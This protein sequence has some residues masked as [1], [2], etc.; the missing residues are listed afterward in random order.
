MVEEKGDDID[1]AVKQHRHAEDHVDDLREGFR[2]DYHENAQ[3]DVGDGSDDKGSQQV[4]F[5]WFFVRHSSMTSSVDSFVAELAHLHAQ[6]AVA[7][8]RQIQLGLRDAFR[9]VAAVRTDVGVA[10]LDDEILVLQEQQNQR[11][12][13]EH[14]VLR[15]LEVER[16][17][18]AVDVDG[19]LIDAGQGMKDDHILRCAVELFAVEH[20]NVLLRLIFLLALE[21]LA[22]DARHIE[23]VEV[24]DGVGEVV[25][26]LIGTAVFLEDVDDIQRHAQLLGRDQHKGVALVLCQRL[27]QR[28]DGPAVEQVAADAD[29]HVIEPALL[30]AERHDIGERLGGMEMSA[31][32]AVDQRHLGVE[33]RRHGGSLDGMADGDDVGIAADDGDGVL[34]ALALGDGGIHG[35]VEADGAPAQLEHRGLEG[36]LRAGA[37][38]VEQRR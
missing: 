5:L 19:D 8:V 7:Q 20:K 31:V 6:L 1:D 21:A 30:A 4:V 33:R 13:A 27:D 34:E 12:P 25:R 22:L 15:L 37:R 3:H 16:A 23:D 18:V 17:R 24:D 9:I 29:L 26:N 10:G 38:L 36:H 35:I 28:V 14:A 2:F 32:A 11:H